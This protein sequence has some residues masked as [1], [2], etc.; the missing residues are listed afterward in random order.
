MKLIKRGISFAIA[1][2]FLLTGMLN[3]FVQA[4]NIKTSFQN[5]LEVHVVK[6]TEE[7]KEV[8]VSNL[9]EKSQYS[10]AIR[11]IENDR[12]EW[13]SN[14]TV[15]DIK[16]YNNSYN[17]QLLNKITAEDIANNIENYI[18]ANVNINSLNEYS[19][20]ELESRYIEKDSQ[21]DNHEENSFSDFLDTNIE[22][23]EDLDYSTSKG[24]S[25]YSKDEIQYSSTV[26]GGLAMGIQGLTANKVETII[27]GL[28][29]L[30]LAH[31]SNQVTGILSNRI[32]T[33]TSTAL[34]STDN[35]TEW[36]NFVGV[37]GAVGT[38]ATKHMTKDLVKNI[39]DTIKN[40]PNSTNNLEV[41]ISTTAPKSNTMIVYDIK[42]SIK[43]TVNFHLANNVGTN[44][45]VDSKFPNVP[46]VDLN[47][48][49][50]FLV[51]NENN[52]TIFHAHFVPTADRVVELRYMRYYDNYDLR[53][54]PTIKYEFQY[55]LSDLDNDEKDKIQKRFRSL[56]N[57][58]P[59]TNG[60]KS[61]VPR[62]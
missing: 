27:L 12:Y 14:V 28:L 10:I 43:G 25:I 58:L 51:Y 5:Y 31:L 56:R 54:Y 37:P 23:L 41:Y 24:D 1:M 59:G 11:K 55:N 8:T 2:F 45:L 17:I 47:G 46:N 29:V 13:I 62:K 16:I 19:K 42:T 26:T 44:T 9:L 20:Q 22:F 49:T 33:S 52:G 50:V 35:S 30:S 6:D 4:K 36:E 21:L 40:K 53:I 61:V 38:S 39:S 18:H 15:D 34:P 7:I 57:L 60:A 3:N 32:E 48:Y